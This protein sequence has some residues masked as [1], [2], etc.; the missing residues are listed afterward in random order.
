MHG[1][2]SSGQVNSAD[3]VGKGVT[4]V[5]GDGMGDTI[6]SIQD[7]TGCSSRGVEGEYGL[8]R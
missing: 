6:T 7:Q 2:I 8:D 3:G 4:L 5:D 1:Q